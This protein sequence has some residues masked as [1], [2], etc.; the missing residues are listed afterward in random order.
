MG[1]SFKIPG[2]VVERL[3]D[4]GDL[5]KRGQPIAVL[6]TSDL[7]AQAAMRRA[8]LESA[9]AALAELLAGSRPGGD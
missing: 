9:R 2:H 4:E 7:E 8:E 6:D 3:V 5:V 1:I